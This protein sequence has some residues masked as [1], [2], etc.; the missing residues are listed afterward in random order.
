MSFVTGAEEREEE[1]TAGRVD[2]SE[3]CEDCTG[4]WYCA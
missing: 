3:I 2:D 1:D 4:M